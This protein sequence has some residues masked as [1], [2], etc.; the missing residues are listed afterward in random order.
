MGQTL[1]IVRGW[2]G[3]PLERSSSCLQ[4]RD[5][6]EQGGLQG[7][8]SKPHIPGL[9]WAGLG[10]GSVGHPK[11]IILHPEDSVALLELS[12]GPL[13]RCRPCTRGDPAQGHWG[14]HRWL[15]HR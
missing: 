5:T 15:C 1:Q 9:G 14:T 10:L 12:Q 2:G 6:G 8:P 13:H 7:S 3:T 11:S 4:G